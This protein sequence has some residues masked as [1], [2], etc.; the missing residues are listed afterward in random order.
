MT[1][2]SFILMLLSV[3]LGAQDYAQVYVLGKS[4]HGAWEEDGSPN[5]NNYGL[6]LGYAWEI[7]RSRSSP[8]LY[9]EAGVLMYK[10][11]VG[12]TAFVG[13]AMVSLRGAIGPFI[14]ELGGGLAYWKSQRVYGL[15]PIW[16]AG[17]GYSLGKPQLFVEGSYEPTQKVSMGWLKLSIPVN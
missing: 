16:Y 12:E 2:N 14:P 17:V 9:T 11:S 4:H 8:R 3:A 1:C 6:G 7:K 10:D 13:S 5:E 15:L